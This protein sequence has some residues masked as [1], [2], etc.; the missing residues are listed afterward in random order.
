M[1]IEILN[2]FMFME[3]KSSFLTSS[4]TDKN[5]KKNKKCMKNN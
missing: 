1:I 5:K 4:I 2:R 3:G